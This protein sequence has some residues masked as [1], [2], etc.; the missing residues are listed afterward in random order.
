MEQLHRTNRLIHNSTI[1]KAT[2]PAGVIKI[3]LSCA[4]GGCNGVLSRSAANKTAVVKK[5]GNQ[6][7]EGVN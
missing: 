4:V 7:L 6:G 5:H 1:G 2:W 3:G